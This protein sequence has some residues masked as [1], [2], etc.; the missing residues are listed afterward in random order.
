MTSD[1]RTNGK[2]RFAG[3]SIHRVGRCLLISVIVLVIGAYA[4]TLDDATLIADEATITERLL[5]GWDRHPSAL[6]ALAVCSVLLGVGFSARRK[7]SGSTHDPAA[8]PAIFPTSASNTTTG[9]DM[10]TGASLHQSSSTAPMVSDRLDT[11]RHSRLQ[12]LKEATTNIFDLYDLSPVPFFLIDTVGEICSANDQA[13]RLLGFSKRKLVGRPLADLAV[14]KEAGEKAAAFILSRSAAGNSTHERELEMLPADERAVWVCLSSRPVLDRYGR[15]LL[16]GVTAVNIAERKTA[17][18]ALRESE[19]RFRRT[20]DESPIGAA[21]VS[22]DNRFVRVNSELCRITGFT[23]NELTA[24]GWANVVHPEN[25]DEILGAA[26]K[27]LNDEVKQFA[28][29]CRLI[30]KDGCTVWVRQSVRVMKDS[31]GTPVYYLPMIEDITLRKQAEEEIRFSEERFRLLYENAPAPYQSLNREGELIEVNNAWCQV[32]GYERGE[33]IGRSMTDFLTEESGEAYQAC[34]S[35]FKRTG[36]I[37]GR[38]FEIVSRDSKI[39]TVLIDGRAH[40]DGDGEFDRSHCVFWDITDRKEAEAKLRQ[41]EQLHR[42]L[43]E[44]MSE[45]VLLRDIDGRITY[46]NERVCELLGAS[47]EALYGRPILEFLNR[48]NRRILDKMLKSSSDGDGQPFELTWTRKNGKHVT[49][50]VSP[51]DVKAADGSLRGS[52]LVITDV[53]QLRRTEAMLK[54]TGRTLESQRHRLEDKDTALKQ[55]FEHLEQEKA[56][57]KAHICSDI[58]LELRPLLR[59]IK[60]AGSP[61]QKRRIDQAGRKLKLLLSQDVGTFDK[62]FGELTPREREVCRLIKEGLSSK[63]MSQH[64]NLSLLTIHKHRENIRKKLN[65]KNKNVNLSTYLHFR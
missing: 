35:E 41:S 30:R 12:E 59:M 14:D 32:F 38:E 10:N 39:R 57:F 20:F 51:A 56:A 15:V 5:T 27:L 48:R 34:F 60:S 4:V 26:R 24:L 36:Q 52:I 44:T 9:S 63:E 54:R 65:V 33:V 55:V 21:M 7:Q 17:T 53:S 64:L 43:I 40:F 19:E 2:Q 18:A 6:T 46:A 13:A 28:V 1:K 3:V 45:G 37:S 11:G 47:G 23:E 42:T 16:T 22:L 25:L 31:H 58:E 62:R 49:T 8:A 50:M 61:D 29:D